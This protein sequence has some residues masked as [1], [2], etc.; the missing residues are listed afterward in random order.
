MKSGPSRGAEREC[1]PD[2]NIKTAYSGGVVRTPIGLTIRFAAVP[3]VA[4]ANRHRLASRHF[5]YVIGLRSEGVE[6]GVQVLIRIGH[7]VSGHSNPE[8]PLHRRDRDTQW[9]LYPEK[10]GLLGNQVLTPHHSA[11]LTE[12]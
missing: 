11:S 1:Y 7:R 12:G 3:F 9:L 5:K 2:Y 8:L 10:N 6:R 4:V